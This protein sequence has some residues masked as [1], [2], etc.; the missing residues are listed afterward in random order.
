MPGRFWKYTQHSKSLVVLIFHFCFKT[1][2]IIENQD[3][4][5]LCFLTIP[6]NI[7]KMD[8]IYEIV[9][10]GVHFVFSMKIENL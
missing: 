4:I 3:I 2:S 1:M 8:Y 6:L 5:N 7:M 10:S 9:Y